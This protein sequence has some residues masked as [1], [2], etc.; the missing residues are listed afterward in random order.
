[1]VC[2]VYNLIICIQQIQSDKK[3]VVFFCFLHMLTIALIYTISMY[4]LKPYK[5]VMD[6]IKRLHC[7]IASIPKLAKASSWI[8][9]DFLQYCLTKQ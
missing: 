7:A 5:L 3:C 4:P 9:I 8:F 2:K 1:M 6:F